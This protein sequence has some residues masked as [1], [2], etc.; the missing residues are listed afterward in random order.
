MCCG[1]DLRGHTMYLRPLDPGV[2]LRAGNDAIAE[3]L[4][5]HGVKK[6]ELDRNERF[7]LACISGRR[8]EALAPAS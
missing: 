4:L 2:A 5:E 7:A 6:V 1:R 8:A 3:Y